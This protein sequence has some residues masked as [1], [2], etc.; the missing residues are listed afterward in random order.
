MIP[1][2]LPRR[3]ALHQWLPVWKEYKRTGDPKLRDRLIFTYAP[4]VKYIVHSKVKEIPSRCEMS[5]LVS[6][7]IEALMHSIERYDPDRGPTLEQFAWTRI[8]GTILD[9]LRRQDWAPR[10]VR[11]WERDIRETEQR[12][13]S[14]YNRVPSQVELAAAMGV[15][16]QELAKW[17]QDISN[18]SVTSLQS[19]AFSDDESAVELVETLPTG[20]RS[21]DPEN[22]ATAQ[23]AK[24]KFREVFKTLPDR[25]RQVAILLYVKELT[26]REV[27]EVLGVTES[28]ISQ[29]HSGLKKQIRA[30]L[31]KTDDGSLFRAIA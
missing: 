20:D 22:A 15:D 6:C 29:I 4:M 5:D 3:P 9:E 7:G 28:R 30:Q 1:V 31:E 12:F 27:G 19:L 10:S 24:E 11:K 26:M 13:L 21:S 23:I 14:L 17:Q 8:H 25:E 2:V 16:V 18:S